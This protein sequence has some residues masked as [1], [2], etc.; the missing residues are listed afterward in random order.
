MAA[1]PPRTRHHLT[2]IVREIEQRL[3]PRRR[4]PS[5]PAVSMGG[6]NEGGTKPNAKPDIPVRRHLVEERT[7]HV[8]VG[9][10]RTK[11]APLRAQTLAEQL[12]SAGLIDFYETSAARTLCDLYHATAGRSEG[13]GAYES[14]PPAGAPWDKAARKASEIERQRSDLHQFADLMRAMCG[15]RNEEGQ[16]DF[17][18]ELFVILMQA[19]VATVIRPTL[20]QIG[21]ARSEYGADR[22][23]TAAGTTILREA[24]KR[25]AIHLGLVY[26]EPWRDEASLRI[27]GDVV[28]RLP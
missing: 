9:G 2:R 10:D 17:D 13:V 23:R 18:R 3:A 15:V 28:G 26:A 14:R 19:C 1:M 7:E 25:G 20:A 6:A 5:L 27:T 24:L 11:G 4:K 8:S 16:Y 12:Y 21:A 22:Q